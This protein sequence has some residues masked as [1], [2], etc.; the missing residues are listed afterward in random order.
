MRRSLVRL[1]AA[2]GLIWACSAALAQGQGQGQAQLE[3]RSPNGRNAVAVAIDGEKRVTYSVLRDRQVILAPS[4]VMMELDSD[5]IGYGL[6]ISGAER[7]EVDQSYPI[8]ARKAAHGRD[9][10][11]ELIVHL[12]ETGEDARRMDLVVRAYDDGVAFRTVLPLQPR[13][14]A[15]L[16]R[17]EHTEF[18]FPQAYP[19][20]GLNIGSFGRS[21]EGEFDPIDT[22]RTREHN[23]FDVPFLCQAG[24]TAFLLAE[25]DLTDFAGLYFTGLGDGGLGLRAKLSPSLD[26]PRVAVRSLVGSPIETPWRVVMLADHAGELLEST[27]LTDLAEPSRIADTSWIEPGLSVWD[28]WSGPSLASVPQAGTNTATAKA[29]IDFAAANGFEYTLVDEGWYAGAGGAGVV[30]PGADVTRPSDRFDLAEVVRYGREKGVGVWLWANWRALDARMEEALAFY[31][32]SGVVGIKVDFMDRDDQWMVGWYTRLLG[33]AARHRLMVNLHGAFAPRG[34]TRTYPNYM[35]QEGVLGAE[36]NKW[37]RR[38]TADHNVMLAY[39]RGVLGPMD[40]TPGG[41]RNVAPEAFEIRNTLPM[42]QTTRAHGLAMYVVYL[43]PVGMVADSPD[44]YA[45]NPAGL[46]FIRAVPTSWDETRFLAG[47]LGAWIAIARRKGREWYV[48]AMNGAEGRTVELP[49]SDLGSG[50]MTVRRWTDGARPDAV[51]SGSDELDRRRP[52]RLRL[53][54]AGGTALILS[55]AR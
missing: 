35:T 34:L 41:F 18:R 50:P 54:P 55:P 42:V 29:F 22:T 12:S 2:P 33:A 47:E 39:T 32:R 6:Q 25:A 37:S 43:S 20:W 11:R 5:R 7:R 4:A 44:T 24:G 19:C 9:H 23:L 14:E 10:F 15:A 13:T 8:V 52:L 48:G 17:D 49:L 3:L 31:A 53:A 36:Y 1:A 46:D 51:V 16:V 30:R 27:L 40:Y 38:I 21:H 28:W 45:A 26:D